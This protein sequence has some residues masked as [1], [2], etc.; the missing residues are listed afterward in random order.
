MPEK[1]LP[2]SKAASAEE[3]A[4]LALRWASLSM[5]ISRGQKFSAHSRQ[6]VDLGLTFPMVIALHVIAFD[7]TQTMTTLVDHLALSTSATSHLI[8]RLVEL[9]LVERRD[10]QDDRRQK[11][12]VLTDTGRSFVTTMVNSRFAEMHDSIRPLSATTRQRLHDA[13][14]DV[15]AELSHHAKV[16]RASLAADS[17]CNS[18]ARGAVAVETN[19]VAGASDDARAR[20]TVGDCSG[21]RPIG[22]DDDQDFKTARHSIVECVVVGGVAGHPSPNNQRNK[23][24]RS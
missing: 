2:V 7:G 11:V 16:D 9:G 13:L 8:Q 15:V 20:E 19:T 1:V 3:V 23:K 14:V 4:R 21:A 24:D 17:P 18:V 12:V 10:H 22:V 5:S 6:I